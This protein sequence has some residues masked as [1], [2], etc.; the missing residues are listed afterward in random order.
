MEKMEMGVCVSS[1][2]SSLE[3][4]GK[5]GE[6]ERR[7]AGGEEEEFYTLL[8]STLHRECPG[9]SEVGE[10]CGP[11]GKTVLHHGRL[12]VRIAALRRYGALQTLCMD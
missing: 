3:E 2:S 11:E 10:A 4:D 6:G 1:S 5:D 7:E 12:Q 8:D 9:D